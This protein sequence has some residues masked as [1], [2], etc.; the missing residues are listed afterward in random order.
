MTS[1]AKIG[2]L[3]GLVF[4]FIIAFV[5]NG[6]PRF[7]DSSDSNELT[8]NLTAHQNYTPGI[9]DST[10]DTAR[11]LYRERSPAITIQPPVRNIT[12]ESVVIQPAAVEVIAPIIEIPAVIAKKIEKPKLYTVK[13]GDSLSVISQKFYGS[14]NV[15]TG[16]RIISK[17]SKLK[18]HDDIYVGQ[19]LC[20]P[21]INKP[22][23]VVQKVVELNKPATR[24]SNLI[25]IVAEGDSLWSIAVE[26]LGDGK[27]H[28][29]ITKLNNLSDEDFIKAGMKLKIPAN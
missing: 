25:Y 20:I 16:M 6:L 1:D 18:S 14:G 27:R 15:Q 3:L 21:A 22:E 23:N 24:K 11:T 9:A 29:E 19:K 10:R 2:L 26:K 4:I 28:T 8:T 7:F 13:S 17:A 12:E 5:I